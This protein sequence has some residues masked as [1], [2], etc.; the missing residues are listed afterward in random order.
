MKERL[1]SISN[2]HY[3]VVD[4]PNR[5]K[6]LLDRT[7]ANIF[8]IETKYLNRIVARNPKRFPN[9]FYF[10]LSDEEVEILKC[11]N[12]TSNPKAFN[13]GNPKA[14]T[15]EGCYSVAMLLRS[16]LAIER[17]LNIIR[18]FTQSRKSQLTHNEVS[19]IVASTVKG[20]RFLIKAV[21]NEIYTI[22]ECITSMQNRLA[23]LEDLLQ[24]ISLPKLEIQQ[25]INKKEAEQLRNIVR[26][27][28]RNRKQTHKIW[29]QFREHFDLS[30]YQDLPK[31]KFQEACLWLT[32]L[33][34]L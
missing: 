5:P 15:W 30:T 29:K 28:A 11:Q 17:S 33:T 10:M 16:D 31:N 20:D 27:K 4:L 34:K 7:V 19:D 24:K 25:T 3:P 1:I 21:V 13:R 12:V 6:A 23:N 2:I 8:Q 14:F 18:A 32:K 22:K 9:D 26:T